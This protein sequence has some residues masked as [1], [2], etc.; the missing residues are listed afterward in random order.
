MRKITTLLLILTA[1][2]SFSQNKQI[3]LLAGRSFNGTGDIRGY[4][5]SVGFDKYFKKKLKYTASVGSTI[6]DGQFPIFY[7]YPAGNIVDGS[8]RYTT[9]GFQGVYAVGYNFLGSETSE[10]V[11]ELGALLRYQ[12]TSY[13][14]NLVVLYPALTNLPYPVVLFRNRTPQKTAA[15]GAVSQLTYSHSLN[16]K[17]NIGIAVSYQFDTNGDNIAQI[18]FLIGRR[19]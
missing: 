6:H 2:I 4:G 3:K 15:F 18:S 14:D 17:I 10:F 12:S 11:F 13:Y 1:Q 9:A 8:I 7:E 16:K 5:F 19:F